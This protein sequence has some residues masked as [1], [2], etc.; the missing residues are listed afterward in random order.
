LA[1]LGKR[2]KLK[3]AEEEEKEVQ[4]IKEQYLVE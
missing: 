4:K 3:I 1:E 2:G